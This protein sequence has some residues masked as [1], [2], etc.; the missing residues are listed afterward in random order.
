MA[1]KTGERRRSR[2]QIDDVIGMP[3][4]Q[5]EE[6]IG[7]SGSAPRKRATEDFL[8]EQQ[9]AQTVAFRFHAS[10]IRYLGNVRCRLPD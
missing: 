5:E 1:R 10:A 7:E 9:D 3:E 4:E 6:V 8:E 2:L